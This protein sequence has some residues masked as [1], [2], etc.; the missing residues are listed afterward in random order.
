M[1]VDAS[2]F[3]KSMSQNSLRLYQFT[4]ER[5]QLILRA[6]MSERLEKER[7]LVSVKYDGS[8]LRPLE[9]QLESLDG[10][11][12]E[13]GNWVSSIDRVFN[14]LEDIRQHLLTMRDAANTGSADAF[15]LD[16]FY[17][18]AAVGSAVTDPTNLMGNTGQGRWSSKST[19][20]GA[21]SLSATVE[22]RFL[23]NDYVIDLSDGSTMRPDH[24][25]RRL[26]GGGF[27]LDM[28]QLTVISR[29]G[30]SV[31]FTDG[32]NTFDGTIRTGGGGVLSA[33]LYNNFATQ[34]DKDEAT[35]DI[36]AAMKRILASERNFR[37]DDAILGVAS[38]N[39]DTEIET[40]NAEYQRLNDEEISEKEAEM[41]ALMTRFE[42]TERMFSITGNAG[43]AMLEGLFNRQTPGGEKKTVF[44]ILSGL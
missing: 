36:D 23:G 1:V 9:E 12:A 18:N 10:K 26:A 17:L 31:Q 19:V 8:S 29:T 33:W 42:A 15:D 44:G 14:S 2:A 7:A 20:L 5:N 38:G 32:T 11:K 35:A 3:L 34:A 21:G 39:L 24:K 13:L 28:T 6:A 22:S 43:A 25:N 40:L 37:L 16:L 27:D 4:L 41:K 30:D